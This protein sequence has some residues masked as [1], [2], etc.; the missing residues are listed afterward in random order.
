M[1]ASMLTSRPPSHLT[2]M[3]Q[4]RQENFKS[5]C[6]QYRYTNTKKTLIQRHAHKDSH[7]NV[8]IRSVDKDLNKTA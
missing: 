8:S 2:T 6:G 3:T 7:R 5:Q 4:T 1:E